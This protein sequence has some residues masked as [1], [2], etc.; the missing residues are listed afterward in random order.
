M[1]PSASR[2]TAKA[3]SARRAFSARTKEMDGVDMFR[4]ELFECE[5]SSSN[6]RRRVTVICCSVVLGGRCPLTTRCR[7]PRE[8]KSGRISTIR[9]V[10]NNRNGS[11]TRQ[12]MT[13][14]KRWVR[15]DSGSVPTKRQESSRKVKGSTHCSPR[16]CHTRKLSTKTK[17]Y[18]AS[19]LF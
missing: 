2:P 10:D 5:G 11:R 4:S 19:L 6:W 14:G 1:T 16:E 3:S 7:G 8:S 12:T 18:S 15:A 17:G 13:A 9:G